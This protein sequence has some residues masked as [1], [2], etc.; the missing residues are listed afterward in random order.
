M[1]GSSQRKPAKPKLRVKTVEIKGS[2]FL[3]QCDNCPDGY[4]EFPNLCG[5]DVYLPKTVNKGKVN[6]RT[7]LK[8]V[9]FSPLL[10]AINSI[11]Y[12]RVTSKE[13][14]FEGKGDEGLALFMQRFREE[15]SKVLDLFDKTQAE[16]M[17][18]FECDKK[19]KS[20]KVVLE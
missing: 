9:S 20:F 12:Y 17:E 6:E 14:N 15:R 13:T 5:F 16:W 10:E 4:S 2:D 3:L 19:K 1:K 7:E 8:W 11:A 18:L